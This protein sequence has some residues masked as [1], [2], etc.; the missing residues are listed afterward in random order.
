MGKQA[1]LIK[2]CDFTAGYRGFRAYH[3]QF[4]AA[5][6]QNY[7]CFLLRDNKVIRHWYEPSLSNVRALGRTF[8]ANI[9]DPIIRG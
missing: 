2:I 8:S 1:A 9:V 5:T 3:V 4:P 7:S 6:G